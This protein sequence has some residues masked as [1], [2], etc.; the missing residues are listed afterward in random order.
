MNEESVEPI[1]KAVP[2]EPQ[3]NV[4]EENLSSEG[5]L[6]LGLLPASPHSADR[7]FLSKIAALEAEDLDHVVRRFAK[8]TGCNAVLAAAAKREFLRLCALRVLRQETP[9]SPNLLADEFWHRFLVH[10]RAYREFCARHFSRFV[11]H[12][13]MD[14]SKTDRRC[15]EDGRRLYHDC[16]GEEP[17]A[18]RNESGNLFLDARLADRIAVAQE[19]LFGIF[20]RPEERAAAARLK[21]LPVN[22]PEAFTK[23]SDWNNSWKNWGQW[24]KWEKETWDRCS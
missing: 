10:T 16:F 23:W 13:P 6:P 14:Q 1:E 8:E 2:D 11:D 12:E 18:W 20:S 3:T 17:S 19:E 4:A 7:I 22:D 21:T 9:L 5:H 24:S 15:F